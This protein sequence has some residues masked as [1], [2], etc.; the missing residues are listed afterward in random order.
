MLFIIQDETQESLHSD[1]WKK[2]TYLINYT[3]YL[4]NKEEK[5]AQYRH[6]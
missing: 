4:Q 2:L 3:K 6:C 1:R 5:H